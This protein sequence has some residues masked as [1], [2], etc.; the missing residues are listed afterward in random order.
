MNYANKNITFLVSSGPNEDGY[1]NFLNTDMISSVSREGRYLHFFIWDCY[2]ATVDCITTENA[3][4]N[5]PLVLDAI[6]ASFDENPKAILKLNEIEGVK[7][8]DGILID[9]YNSSIPLDDP[10]V[11][12]MVP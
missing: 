5:L 9:T 8:M 1:I 10:I 3:K 2:S 6:S 11:K 4:H 7:G 12:N